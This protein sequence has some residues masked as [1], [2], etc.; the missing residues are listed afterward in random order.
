MSP[1]CATF[2][3]PQPQ[4]GSPSNLKKSRR[5]ER[6]SVPEKSSSRATLYRQESSRSHVRYQSIDLGMQ[7]VI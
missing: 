4:E 5:L 7:K 6:R 2:S 3:E 1:Y